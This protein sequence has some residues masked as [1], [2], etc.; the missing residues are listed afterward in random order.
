MKPS[1]VIFE[2]WTSDFSKSCIVCSSLSTSEYPSQQI[3]TIRHFREWCVYTPRNAK[4][5]REICT[6][7]ERYSILPNAEW[8]TNPSEIW[9]TFLPHPTFICCWL[10][11]IAAVSL[12][13]NMSYCGKK[14]RPFR[15]RRTLQGAVLL[16]QTEACQACQLLCAC[17]KL[18]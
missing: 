13:Q 10:R 16:L 1:Y 12:E 9:Y 4:L 11:W 5:F 3:E 2:V 15:T 6:F 8:T 17:F 18:L 14:T 7:Q